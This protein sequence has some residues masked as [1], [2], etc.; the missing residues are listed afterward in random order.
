MANPIT[1]LIQTTESLLTKTKALL[2]AGSA[3]NITGGGVGWGTEVFS[4]TS[5]FALLLWLPELLTKH[6]GK[7]VMVLMYGGSAYQSNPRRAAKVH[8]IC[9][10]DNGVEREN[11]EVTARALLDNAMKYLDDQIDGHIK[12][13]IENDEPLDAYDTVSVLKATFRVRDY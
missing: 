6:A 11:Q 12:W 3:T 1:N 10:V 9:M 8:V 13:E 7:P 4:G 2:V 5:E